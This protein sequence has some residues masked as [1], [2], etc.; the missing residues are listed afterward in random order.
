MHAISLMLTAISCLFVA[1]AVY[2]AWLWWQPTLRAMSQRPITALISRLGQIGFDESAIQSRLFCVELV[3]GVGFVVAAPAY[4]GL[5]LSIVL[6]CIYMHARPMFF[7]H[8]IDKREKLLRSQTLS[9]TVAIQGLTQSGLSLPQ[10]IIQAAPQTPA[11]LGNLIR[12]VSSNYR[13]GRPIMEAISETRYALHLDVFSLLVTSITCAIQQGTPIHD[14]L[15]G[16]QEILE[17]RDRVERQ[18]TAQTAS[19]RSTIKI[20]AVSPFFF[21]A[22][23]WLFMPEALHDLFNSDS[24]KFILSII[25]ATFYCGLAWAKKLLRIQ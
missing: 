14:A 5:Y 9:L 19:A 4:F 21:L 6:L 25:A 18:L 3:L 11:P 7:T 20:L 2:L 22:A 24:G 12:R 1:L 10:S 13:H 15:M 16:V 8:L 23:F 17:N